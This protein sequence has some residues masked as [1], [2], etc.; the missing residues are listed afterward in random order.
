MNITGKTAVAESKPAPYALCRAWL[1][2]ERTI[3]AIWTGAVWWAEGRQ[4]LPT[5][6]ARLTA[7]G[8]VLKGDT[9][10]DSTLPAVDG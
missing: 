6:W 4:I 10:T 7:V 2:D 9:A 8:N 5:H 1:A 3:A